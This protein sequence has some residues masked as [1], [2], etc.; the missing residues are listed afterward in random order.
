[1]GFFFFF[2]FL[3]DEVKCS[4]SPYNGNNCS[5]G[6]SASVATLGHL[7]IKGKALKSTHRAVKMEGAGIFT[8]RRF[9]RATC[10]KKQ[11]VTR[12]QN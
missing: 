5:A 2:F 3:V 8:V 10:T 4:F 12:K 6:S 11:K 7:A 9:P 1:M